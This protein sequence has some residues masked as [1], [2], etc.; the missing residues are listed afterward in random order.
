MQA[1]KNE[2]HLLDYWRVISK[3]RLIVMVFFTIVVGIV[4]VY[5]FLATP[6]YEGTAKIFFEF[7]KNASLNFAQGEG[8]ASFHE[9]EAAEYLNTQ[10]EILRS[11]KFADWVVRKLQLDKN[12]D[13]LKEKEKQK[14]SASAEAVKKVKAAIKGF[15]PKRTKPDNLAQD[16]AMKL[17]LD[18]ELTTMLLEGMELET[19]KDTSNIF[20]VHFYSENPVLAAYMANGIANAYVDYSLDI[21]IRPY[22][23]VV[24]WL[25]S[26]LTELKDRVESSEMALQAY[27]EGKG[28]VSFE[29]NENVITQKLSQ[30]VSQL[31]EAEGKHHEAEL[32]YNQMKSVINNPDLLAT[33]PDVMNNMVIQGLR[34]EE[35][36]IKKDISEMSGKYGPKHPQM[37][38]AQSELLSVRSDLVSEAR[39]MLNAAK[40]ELEI[41][42]DKEASLH[43]AYDEQKRQVLDLSRAAIEY[44]VLAGGAESNKQFYELLLKKFQEATLSSG[45]NISNAQIADYAITPERPIKPKKGLNIILS[46][47][48]GLFGGIGMA[49]FAE[50]MENTIT[51][52]DDVEKILGLPF[53]GYIPE[54]KEGGPLFMSTKSDATS[55]I[56]DSFRTLNTSLFLSSTEERPQVIMVTSTTPGEGKTTT[57]ANLAIAMA[58]TGE[59]VLLIDADLRRIKLQKVFGLEKS[60]G[61]K[62]LMTSQENPSAA[63]ITVPGYNNLNML[64]GLNY[65]PRSSEL[66]GSKR[67]KEIISELRTMYDRIIIDSP[68]IMAVSDPLVLSRLVDGIILV[69]CSGTTR[70]DMIM[71]S[72][73]SITNVNGKT[74]GVVLNR[75]S[76]SLQDHYPYYNSYRKV[77]TRKVSSSVSL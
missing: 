64:T 30:L 69:V 54:E 5:S 71:K 29:T 68:P 11:R 76:G 36:K 18:P 1:K 73:K 65:T 62:D 77:R 70:R 33:I 23:N 4:T 49:F 53:L 17:E 39:K 28:I 13:I 24:E 43:K 40:A 27:R 46:L 60:I 7:E 9:K 8:R 34:N 31:V 55:L 12:A 32:K 57:A 59:K 10:L 61:K 16:P 35:L 51:T 58:Q 66:F 15:L 44:K 48:V 41:A 52:S 47:G 21:R 37:I 74:M 45:V 25:S 67:M 2:I 14:N 3:R 6:K 19:G 26:R 75:A 38:K 63:I 50:Y 72:I 56:A 42:Q 22:K 20:Y